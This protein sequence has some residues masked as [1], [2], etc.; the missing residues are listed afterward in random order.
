MAKGLDGKHIILA[1]SRKT[2]EMT[3][4]IKRQGGSAAVLPAQGTVFLAEKEVQPDL[5]RLIKE[6][7][8]WVILTT[9]I[10]TEKLFEIAENIGK[11]DKFLQVLKRANIAIRGYKTRAALKKRGIEPDVSDNDGTTRGLIRALEGVELNGKKVTVQLHGDTA[12]KLM[13]FLDEKGAPHTEILPYQHI[14]P[15]DEALEVLYKEIIEGQADAVC[16]TTAMQVR[17]LFQYAKEKNVTA[18]LVEAFQDRVLAVAVGVITAEAL[19]EEGIERILA[20]EQQ[21]MGAMILK[22][23]QYYASEGR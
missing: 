8:D 22:L 12:P 20:P 14:A 19:S 15:E 1:A 23:S 11:G 21:R 6:G 17:F 9:G 16:F 5:E 10:G 4:L 3:E 13:E 18:L 2:E 7:S